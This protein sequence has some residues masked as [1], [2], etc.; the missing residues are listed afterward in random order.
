MNIESKD[1]IQEIPWNYLQNWLQPRELAPVV[2]RLENAILWINLYPVDNR[3]RFVN[4]YP[5][6]GDLSV[7]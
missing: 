4:I 6:K 5:L 3:A 2:R 7:R 1:A